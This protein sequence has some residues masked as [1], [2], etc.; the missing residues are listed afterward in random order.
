[1]LLFIKSSFY[2]N[3][4]IKLINNTKIWMVSASAYTALLAEIHFRE[5]S[6]MRAFLDIIRTTQEEVMATIL[7]KLANQIIITLP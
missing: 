1:M 4:N 3:Y 5:T 6:A 7:I 2:H